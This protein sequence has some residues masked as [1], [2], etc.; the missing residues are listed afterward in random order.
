MSDKVTPAI[1]GFLAG[2][3]AAGVG[4]YRAVLHGSAARG[5]HLPGWS[6]INIVLV[7]DDLSP[8]TLERLRAPLTRWRDEAGALPLMLTA[9]EWDRSADA[10]PLEIAEMRTAYRVLR[11]T[12]LLTGLQAE[13]AELRQALERELRGKLLR[14][15]QGYALLSDQP[16]ALGEF[17]R[18]S[19]SSVLFLCRGL[20]ILAGRTPPPDAAGLADAAGAVAGFDGPVLSRVAAVRGVEQWECTAADARGYLGAVQQMARYVDTYQIGERA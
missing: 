7:F 18:H 20:L 2:L 8:A 5:Q 3:D 9:E 19:V 10:Y 14:L 17:L 13:P 6:D 4:P 12:D 16:R 11:G 15:R 1:E